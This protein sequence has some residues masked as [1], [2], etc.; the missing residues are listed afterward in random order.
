[1]DGTYIIQ[2]VTEGDLRPC[3]NVSDIVRSGVSAE[4]RHLAA[5]RPDQLS[6]VSRLVTP[7]TGEDWWIAKWSRTKG[8]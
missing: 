2:G 8:D 3:Q 4:R 7:A 1:M 6:V 5:E